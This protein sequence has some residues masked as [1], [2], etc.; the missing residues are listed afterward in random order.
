[1]SIVF[2][3]NINELTSYKP[4]KSVEE[5]KKELNLTEV[6]VLWNGENNLG[7]SPKALNAISGVLLNS[8]LYPDPSCFALRKKISAYTGH[9]PEHIFVGNGSEELLSNAIKAFCQNGDEIVTSAGTFVAIYIW[10]K[11]HDVPLTQV[12]LLKDFSIDLNG[13]L[14]AIT[15]STKLIYLANPNNPTGSYA[16]ENELKAFLEKVPE[17]IVV[18]V[19]EAYFEY[20]KHM[21]H[22]FPDSSHL[23]NSNVMTL[24]TFS[25]TMGIAGIRIGYGIA[26][27]ELTD[28]MMKVKMT[29]APSSVAQAA[30]IGALNDIE[31][32]N[33]TIDLNKKSLDYFYAELERLNVFYRK[34][35][36]NF[37]LI[38]FENEQEAERVS[39]ELMKKGVFVRWLKA[40]GLPSAIRVGTGKPNENKLFVDSLRTVIS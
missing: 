22:D 39:A 27:S 16:T 11:L 35:L 17:H 28:A 4:G 3:A 32:L 37:V 38:N 8:H 21:D 1:M 9:H 12:P 7:P 33:E 13:I 5:I 25:K 29:F 2:P 14:N 40:F 26:P 31:F 18:V 10:S 19:D 36:G 6:A 30:G 23:G 15:S 24:R 34:S 20:A